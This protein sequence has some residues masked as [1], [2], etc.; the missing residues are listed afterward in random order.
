MC[1]SVGSQ[2]SG[3]NQPISLK[4]LG[5]GNEQNGDFAPIDLRSPGSVAKI[6]GMSAR[7]DR[8]QIVRLL[9][10]KCDSHHILFGHVSVIFNSSS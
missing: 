5:R 8:A 7:K 4:T 3:C 1:H 10:H 6:V 2:D 9:T